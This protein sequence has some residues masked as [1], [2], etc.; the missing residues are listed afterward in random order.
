MAGEIAGETAF[1]EEEEKKCPVSAE[2]N[3]S[4]FFLKIYIFVCFILNFYL[5]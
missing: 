3:F 1:G 2:F 5:W 4:C